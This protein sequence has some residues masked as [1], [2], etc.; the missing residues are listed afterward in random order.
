MTA[1]KKWSAD[2]TEHSDAL[3]LERHVFESDDAK[4]I[5]A[6]LKRS[7]EH[8]D[9][10]KAEPFQSAM[11]MLNFYINRAGKNLPDERKRV[12]EKAKDELRVAFGRGKQD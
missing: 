8:S 4:K 7:A 10:R 1:K 2:V 3:D 12:L 6:S 11:S 5:A 9:R